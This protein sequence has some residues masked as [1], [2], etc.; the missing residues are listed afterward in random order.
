MDMVSLKTSHHYRIEE[1]LVAYCCTRV[2]RTNKELNSLTVMK[3]NRILS[4]DLKVSSFSMRI[5]NM[6]YSIFG[7]GNKNNSEQGTLIA[8]FLE[9]EMRN[10]RLDNLKLK[11]VINELFG[12][13]IV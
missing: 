10:K 9:K 2:G 3:M 6:S 12:E 7:K 4:S 11:C 13:E 1:D 8:N 5:G